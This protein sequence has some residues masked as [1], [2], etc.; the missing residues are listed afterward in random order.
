M[1][2]SKS[3]PARRP[4]DKISPKLTRVSFEPRLASLLQVLIADTSEASGPLLEEGMGL[5][6]HVGRTLSDILAFLLAPIRWRA[7]HMR[8]TGTQVSCG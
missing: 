7:S 2:M 5:L 1:K 3:A 4:A 8:P 6:L